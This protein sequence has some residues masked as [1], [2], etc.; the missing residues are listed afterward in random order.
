MPSPPSEILTWLAP[1]AAD[2]L[3][4]ETF[5]APRDLIWSERGP[6]ADL[7]PFHELAS[8]LAG[9]REAWSRALRDD[10]WRV[11]LAATVALLLSDNRDHL[12][13]LESR[14]LEGSEVA[15]LLAVALGQLHPKAC[16]AIFAR[17]EEAEPGTR[18]VA[19]AL[20]VLEALGSKAASRLKRSPAYEAEMGSVQGILRAHEKARQIRQHRDFWA[21]PPGSSGSS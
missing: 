11:S 10:D 21:S 14:F 3:P 15:P 8:R 5:L 19:E 16:E 2:E 20:F 12:E 1:D 9:D 17:L 18:G 6:A 13:D 4:P 7:A